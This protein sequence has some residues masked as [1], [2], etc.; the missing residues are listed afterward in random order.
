[1]E[2]LNLS[3]NIRRPTTP[4]KMSSSNLNL[5]DSKIIQGPSNESITL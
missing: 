5:K 3:P 2:K 4:S 1:V